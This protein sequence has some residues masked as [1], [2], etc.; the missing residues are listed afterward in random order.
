VAGYLIASLAF[1]LAFALGV[2]GA[3]RPRVMLGLG[4]VLA[5]GWLLA[6][7]AGQSEDELGRA[8]IPL[9]LLAGL[10]VLLYFIWCGGLWLG[11]RVRRARAR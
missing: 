10:V 9:W 11:L 4:A 3:G 1:V 8:S 2:T 6:L 7:A 5:L